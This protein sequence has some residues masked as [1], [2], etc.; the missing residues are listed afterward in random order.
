MIINNDATSVVSIHSTDGQLHAFQNLTQST[1][2][3]VDS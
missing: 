2:A 3:Y 1:P